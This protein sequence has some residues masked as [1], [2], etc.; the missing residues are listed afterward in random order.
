MNFI[1]QLLIDFGKNKI[2]NSYF[3]IKMPLFL[4]YYEIKK[5]RRKKKSCIFY[6]ILT[7]CY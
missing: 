4:Q 1:V 2:L 3:Y 7:K 5:R 6:R